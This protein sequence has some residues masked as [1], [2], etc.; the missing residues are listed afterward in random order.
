[1]SQTPEEMA[2]GMSHAAEQCL[3]LAER[4]KV[5]RGD[6]GSAVGLGMLGAAIALLMSA[7][8]DGEAIL[9]AAREVI[10]QVEGS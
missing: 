10:A 3:A 7:G 9:V 6:S 2:A 8:S 1:M 5:T 4:L